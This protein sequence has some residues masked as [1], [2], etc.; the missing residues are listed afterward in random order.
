M[1]SNVVPGFN[2][3]F[4]AA[5]EAV[6]GTAVAP[7]NAAAYAA[8]ALSTIECDL[9]DAQSGEV[10]AKQD[11]GLSRDMQDGFV[12]GRYAPVPWNVMLSLKTRAAAD[13]VPGEVALWKSA[14]LGRTVNAATSYVLAPTNTP[15]ESAD[16]VTQ[17]FTRIVGRSP[18]E[19]EYERLLGCFA[20][21]VKIEGGDKEVMATFSGFGREKATGTSV[22]SITVL[23]AATTIT[24]TAAESY[25]Y[26]AGYYICESEVI[27]V[28]PVTY[29]GTTINITRAQLGTAAAAHTAQPIYPYIPTGLTYAGNP[30]SEALTTTATIFGIAVPVLKW[31]VTIKTGLSASPGETGSP[32][33]QKIVTRRVDVEANFD[34]LLKG[35]DVRHF[36]RARSRAANAVTLVQGTTAGGI[37][38]IGL[39]YTELVAPA[40]KDSANDSITVSC[41]L[42]VRGNA[43]ATPNSFSVTLT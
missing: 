42:R 10:R 32:Y 2:P 9:G 21:T 35:D 18:G 12:E 11:R 13:T 22:A 39:P 37:V 38:T 5:D 25:A 20:D 43:G 26:A 36:N 41:S 29:G 34:L 1:G 27:L 23:I 31:G 4:F 6:L 14:G 15:V 40:A 3:V 16:L 30:I 33:F 7:A 24:C 19:M 28:G 8:Q 17:T